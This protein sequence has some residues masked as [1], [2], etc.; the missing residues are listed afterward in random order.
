[1]F[2]IYM[3]TINPF[4]PSVAFY[5]ETSHMICSANQM[6]GFYRT[7]NTGLKWVMIVHIGKRLTLKKIFLSS[8]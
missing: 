2:I 7:C 4:Y 5:N 3:E 8:K 1:M 6:N